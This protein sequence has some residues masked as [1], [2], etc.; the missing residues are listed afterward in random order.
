MRTWHS[1]LVLLLKYLLN[2]LP[3]FKIDNAPYMDL[4]FADGPKL[5]PYYYR[6]DYVGVEQWSRNIV[7]SHYLHLVQLHEQHQRFAKTWDNKGAPRP[8]SDSSMECTTQSLSTVPDRG[9]RHSR[10]RTS[11]GKTVKCPE[12]DMK[13]E[14]YTGTRETLRILQLFFH[15]QI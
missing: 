6:N 15:Q 12:V 9:D 11:W 5:N 2:T 10:S 7:R 13:F 8:R 1:H 4:G 14:R 3:N